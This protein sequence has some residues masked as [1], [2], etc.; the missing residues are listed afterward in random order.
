MEFLVGLVAVLITLIGF[1]I[2]YL[3]GHKRK[4]FRWSEYF[5][6]VS[7]PIIS[8]LVLAYYIDHRI[9]TLFFV[10]AVAG[11]L[12]EYSFAFIYHKTLNKRLWTYSRFALNGYTS[13]LTIPVWGAAGIVFWLLGKTLGL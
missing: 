10:S 8:A 11:F 4:E 2:S 1:Y 3:Y 12:F 9:L 5:L 13:W 6:L 7:W